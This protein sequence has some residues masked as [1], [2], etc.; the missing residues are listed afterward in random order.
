[1]NAPSEINAAAVKHGPAEKVTP[2]MQQRFPLWRIPSVHRSY[3]KR[4]ARF[5]R[6]R[7][8]LASAIFAVAAP[9]SIP[10][11]ACDFDLVGRTFLSSAQ[12]LQSFAT[13]LDK[14]ANGLAGDNEEA[15][16]HLSRATTSIVTS[17]LPLYDL[18]R[19][20]TEM[21]DK[22]DQQKV[23]EVLQRSLYH[24]SLQIDGQVTFSNAMIKVLTPSA[25]HVEPQARGAIREA[26]ALQS[27]V[28]PCIAKR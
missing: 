27:L 26:S 3:A 25:A 18:F 19:L 7:S 5:L 17:A 10:T 13:K 23:T 15:T 14:T 2:M 12:H 24:L 16:R 4:Y 20:R 22:S 9:T 21:V 1:M 11:F 8:L 6:P 28:R